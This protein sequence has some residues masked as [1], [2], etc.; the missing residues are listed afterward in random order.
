MLKLGLANK[1]TLLFSY[2]HIVRC[3]QYNGFP[4]ERHRGHVWGSV[5]NTP[6]HFSFYEYMCSTL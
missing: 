2:S 1:G 6:Q 4:C 5:F 3:M